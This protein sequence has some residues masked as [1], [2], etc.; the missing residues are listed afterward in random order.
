M[1]TMADELQALLDRI[2][3]EGLKRAEVERD[4]LLS[5]ARAEAARIRDESLAEAEK[6]VA[7]SRREAALLEEKGR[8]A[9]RQAARDVLLSL[10]E[11]LRER[12]NHTLRGAIGQA[13]TPQLMA[14]LLREVAHSFAAREGDPQRLGISL[15]PARLETV[16]SELLGLLGASLKAEAT[17]HPLPGGRDGFQVSFSGQDVVYD[18]TDEALAEVLCAF[19]SPKLAELV[20]TES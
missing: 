13:M 11:R 20:H 18:F 14:D 9:L 19:L 1:D 15:A 5:K 16:R 7:E 4:D 8:Q 17:L 12:L 2:A 3:S 6:T 10:R